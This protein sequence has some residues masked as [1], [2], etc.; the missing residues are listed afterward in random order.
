VASIDWY[1]AQKY[2]AAR[3]H[4]ASS[5]QVKILDLAIALATR[6]YPWLT[7]MGT[8]HARAIVTAVATALGVEEER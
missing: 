2:L 1:K 7:G 5:S 4:G 8:A 3:P 6:E